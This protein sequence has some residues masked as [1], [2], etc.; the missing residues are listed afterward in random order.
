[1]C[2]VAGVD[3]GHGV[4]EFGD[5]QQLLRGE[6]GQNALHV[7][8]VAGVVLGEALLSFLLGDDEDLPAVL[9]VALPAD[10]D[11]ALEAV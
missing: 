9:G 4:E 7:L 5:G 10:I 1:M 8:A 11:A 6:S 3:V 2:D